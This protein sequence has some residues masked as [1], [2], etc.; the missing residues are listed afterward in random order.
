[1]QVTLSKTLGVAS[2]N[3]NGRSGRA[4]V[5]AK[6]VPFEIV[7]S[8]PCANV[9]LEL[10]YEETTS[11]VL[12]P[13]PLAWTTADCVVSVRVLVLSSQHQGALF[14]I[15]VTCNGQS[16]LTP[17]IRVISK[18]S[19]AQKIV[20]REKSS[21]TSGGRPAKRQKT[22]HESSATS[23]SY[24]EESENEVEFD[25]E[26]EDVKPIKLARN[27]H[28]NSTNH[29]NNS[30]CASTTTTTSTQSPYAADNSQILAMLAS[31]QQQQQEQSALLSKLVS[32]STSSASPHPSN[33]LIAPQAPVGTP[34]QSGEPNLEKLFTAFLDASL[35]VPGRPELFRKM[36]QSLS[37]D[38]LAIVGELSSCLL[39]TAFDDVS[40]NNANKLLAT[41]SSSSSLP[42]H[43]STVDPFWL[44][45]AEESEHSSDL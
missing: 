37:A 42:H 22:Q 34:E 19:Q 1:M 21:S 5:S 33:N 29:H 14:K 9:L 6:N 31:L 35:K 25:E 20:D 44:G 10:V 11:P 13:N 7:L 27:S 32:S 28:N 15:K 38:R 12:A 40:S 45:V 36:L 24:E 41:T 16:A 23:D 2:Y 26:E 43:T 8:Q 4:H 3:K 39:T 18:R 30:T 17:P